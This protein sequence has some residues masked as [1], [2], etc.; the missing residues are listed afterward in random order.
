MS[1][2]TPQVRA[3][4]TIRSSTR[5]FAMQRRTFLT[6]ALSAAA[7]HSF[8]S[9][10]EPA[11]QRIVDTHVHLWDLNRL[12]LPWIEK[13]TPLARSYLAK[14]YQTAI[15]GLNV[16]KGVYMEVDVDARDLVTEAEFVLELC[17]QATSPVV[18]AVIG[19]RPANDDFGKYLDR[20]RGNRFLKGV[21]Q[22]LH[23]P[24]AKPG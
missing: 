24:T 5:E 15:Q 3:M 21:R 10:G 19:G 16:V 6:S 7:S 9:A 20:F 23:T 2:A 8:A 13:G 1:A 17:R 14:D 11:N 4:D 22:V 18:A 12:R